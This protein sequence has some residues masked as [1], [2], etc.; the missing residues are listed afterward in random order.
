MNTHS[1]IQFALLTVDYCP[2]SC[3]RVG[4]SQYALAFHFPQVTARSRSPDTVG[5]TQFERQMCTARYQCLHRER[6]PRNLNLASAYNET[7]QGM[8]SSSAHSKL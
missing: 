3:Y 6:A 5:P 1:A 4:L 8:A 2:R 7:M